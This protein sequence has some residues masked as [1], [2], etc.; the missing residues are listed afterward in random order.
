MEHRIRLVAGD[1]LSAEFPRD[2]D[3]I[4][5][6][7]IIHG[8]DAETNRRTIN[9]AL[10]ALN[11]EGKLYILDQ[12]RNGHHGSALAQ[13]IP[14]MVGLNLFNEIGGNTYTVE[15]VKGWCGGAKRVKVMRLRYP[16][17]ALFE[18]S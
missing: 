14:L 8:F 9:R 12:I 2:Q 1:F 15:Q 5:M 6:F 7:N 3:A 16:G 13:F 4:L 11:P 18:V 10:K 17:L